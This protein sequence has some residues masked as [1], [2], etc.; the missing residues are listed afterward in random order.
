MRSGVESCQAG[1]RPVSVPVTIADSA[2][3]EDAQVECDGADPRHPVGHRALQHLDA[4]PGDQHGQRRAGEREDEALDQQL[5]DEAPAPGAERGADADLALAGGGA[6]QLQGRHVDTGNQQH[7][8]D[9]AQQHQHPGPCP[10]P[11]HVVV[12]RLDA[13]QRVLVPLGV[14]GPERLRDLVHARL[15]LR[16]GHP[17][18]QA[19]D[20]L[21]IHAEPVRPPHPLVR[22]HDIGDVEVGRARRADGV[23]DVRGQ[24]ADDLVALALQRNGSA[25]EAGIT[26]EPPAPQRVAEDDDAVAA[27]HFVVDG[28][29]PAQGGCDPQHPEE[30]G[31]GAQ[32]AEV[33]GLRAGL[34]ERVAGAGGR[35]QRLED[36]L[37]GRPV[38][39]VLRR[40]RAEGRRIAG[41]VGF[42]RRRPPF[43]HRHEAVV[44]VER[45]A[46]EDDGVDDGE[47]GGAGADAECQD[48]QCHDGRRWR[49]DQGADGVTQV[50]AHGSFGRPSRTSGWRTTGGRSVIGHAYRCDWNFVCVLMRAAGLSSE[51]STVPI[52]RGE[53]SCTNTSQRSLPRSRWP[54][55]R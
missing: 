37:P 46:A 4:P 21:Q 2:H 43:A 32:G 18:R 35:G 6:R 38:E 41:R 3:A 23:R 10:R 24:H 27:V 5:T 52:E 22:R 40:Y 17:R 45:Q 20:D 12:Q 53:G 31:R 11:D 8:A 1:A 55:S 16:H 7:Q 36:V 26:A 51:G 9:R 54:L 34:V 33:L 30:I 48:D 44:L 39:V 28:E 13:G 42:G 47:D 15:R 50:G 25:D 29:R 49:R 19:A 14:L